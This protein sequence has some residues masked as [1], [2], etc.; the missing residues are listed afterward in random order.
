MLKMLAEK[1]EGGEEGGVEVV[2]VKGGRRLRGGRGRAS[3][4]R[5]EGR[6]I[7]AGMSGGGVED[8][9]GKW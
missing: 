4:G 6:S 2:V 3:H 7:V 1:W 9:S 5:A 8:D